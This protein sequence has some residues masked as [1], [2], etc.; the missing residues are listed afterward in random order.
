M[1]CSMINYLNEWETAFNQIS[2]R[3]INNLNSNE[4][5]I[6]ELTGEQSHFIRFNG[7]KVRQTGI[8]ID[9]NIKLKLISNQR[10]NYA[11]FPLTGK[12]ETDLATAL[13]NLDHLRQ[14]IRLLPEDPYI[15]LPQNQG[16]SREVYQGKLL[17]TDSA[18]TEI[19][20]VVQGLDFTG[21]YTSGSVIRA[22]DN[23]LGQKHW[24]S[25]DSFFLDYSLITPDHKAVKCTFAERNWDC[26]SYRQQIQQGKNQLLQLDKPVYHVK[27]GRYRTYFAPAAVAD[28][29]A[30]FSWGAISEASLRQG[31]SAL[32]KMRQGKTLSPQF[33]LKENFAGGNVP[34]FNDLGEIT[35]MEIPLII[36]GELINTLISSR[37]AAEYGL[38]S[39][40]ASSSEGL[41]APEVSG[42]KLK[43]ED[44]L[45][46][47]DTGLYLSNLHY[48]NWSDR[49]GGRITGMT[50]YACFWV[51]KGEIIAPIQDLRFDDSLYS[52]LG[53]NLIAL[54]QTRAFIPRVDTYE[55][56]SLGGL[57]MPGLLVEDFTFTL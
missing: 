17:A 4:Y 6:L 3:L 29:I 49:P 20:P 25:T 43:Q 46:T 28:L 8:V 32:A 55:K 19:L 54:T 23:S 47:L 35:P 41:R 42:G 44:I 22:N 40:A 30:M 45:K 18:V 11:T 24:F 31:G 16:S 21:F 1:I 56:R 52:F 14:E 9:S 15:V 27:P 34:R 50:R 51:E 57:L 13:E 10:T 48:L 2:D 39:N 26:L 37:T 12:M 7:A 36:Q 38:V 33:N 53:N 5:L